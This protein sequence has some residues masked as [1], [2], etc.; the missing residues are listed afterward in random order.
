MIGADKMKYL[1]N[2][3]TT[4]KP[5][6]NKNWW[7]DGGIIT[8][9]TIEAETITEALKKYQKNVLEKHYISISDNAIKQKQPIYID[10]VNEAIQT[11]F[12][13]TGKTEFEDRENYKWSTQYID[14]WIDIQI[15]KNPFLE[16]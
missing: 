13:I 5:Y 6:N 15:V 4:M 14:L 2:T 3:T 8:P 12:V 11:G 9:K 10:T 7:I 16:V 1:F